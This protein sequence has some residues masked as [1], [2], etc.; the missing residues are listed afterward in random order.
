MRNVYGSFD[1]RVDAINMTGAFYYAGAAARH[2]VSGSE[3]GGV[4]IGF[5]ASRVVPTGTENVPAHYKQ[6]VALYLGR[7]AKV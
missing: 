6:P 7:S 4:V 2:S 3:N 1:P 5:D